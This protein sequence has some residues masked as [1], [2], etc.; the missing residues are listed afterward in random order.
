MVMKSSRISKRLL[1]SSVVLA[2]SIASLLPQGG[3]A[4]EP[5][6]YQKKLKESVLIQ[7]RLGPVA[8]GSGSDDPPRA[9]K[10]RYP[11]KRQIVTTTFWIGEKAAPKNPVPNNMSSWDSRWAE[12]YGGTDSPDRAKR[13]N[14][15]P[16]DFVPKLNPF[17][18]ALPYN[19]VA[20]GE[21]KTEAPVVIPWFKSAFTEAGKSVCKGRWVAIRYKD[22][23]A[24]AQWEDC[25]PFRT[26][27][28]QYVFG[29]ERPK[30]NLN[31]GAG[32][33]VSP[34]V[35]DYLGM[36]DTDIT[37]WSFVDF[38]EVPIGPWSTH[39]EN[40]TFVRNRR[41]DELRVAAE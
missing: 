13:V 36:A 30:P 22:R 35:R 5:E 23:T 18:I 27:H 24:Y 34:S 31:R 25:G 33:D 19:D 11:W 4:S 40:N 9:S 1:R 16:A 12:N 17:Y 21:H 28:W 8:T 7:D 2:S 14:Y 32:L 20:R 29:D 39:G 15:L 41:D 38:H 10:D 6:K 37:D 3:K 26:D